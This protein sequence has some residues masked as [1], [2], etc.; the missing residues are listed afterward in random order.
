M[1]FF[2]NQRHFDHLKTPKS[3]SKMSR[4]RMTRCEDTGRTQVVNLLDIINIL[5]EF[6]F[7][8]LEGWS[9]R[10][11]RL[12]PFL[13]TI[14]TIHASFMPC[15]TLS[16]IL[17]PGTS[18][19]SRSGHISPRICTSLWFCQNCAIFFCMGWKDGQ[20]DSELQSLLS[21]FFVWH[22][23][24]R[25]FN[26]LSTTVTAVFHITHMSMECHQMSH[27]NPIY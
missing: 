7:D 19:T 6:L 1:S 5:S 17:T 22:L 20:C 10:T 26:L 18:D 2:M 24:Y 9:Q 27:V 16:R 12:I 4:P 21:S 14:L 25:T 8:F 3:S 13:P 15:L 23:C 11:W